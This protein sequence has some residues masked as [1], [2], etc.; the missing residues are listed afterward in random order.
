MNLFIKF[1]KLLVKLLKS[2]VIIL[3]ISLG[4]LLFTRVLIRYVPIGKVIPLFSS[5]GWSD[6]ITE[7]IMAWMIFC[8][9]TLI[10]RDKD[11][12]KVTILE[13]KLKGT[14]FLNYLNLFIAILGIFFFGALSKHS[15][16][17]VLGANWT[18]PILKLSQKI[19]YLSILINSCF[20]FIYQ[21]RDLINSC[22]N[23][24]NRKHVKKVY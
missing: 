19:P 7:I 18:T 3:M 20:M 12:F 14:S 10:M 21:I 24:K 9:S 5:M 6:E 1:D 13:E 23:I 8:T 11:H 16:Y 2:I 4:L 17:L 15:F 22:I